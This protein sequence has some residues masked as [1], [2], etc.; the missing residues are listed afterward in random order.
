M[1]ESSKKKTPKKKQS[2]S[3]TSSDSLST[4][5]DQSSVKQSPKPTALTGSARKIKDHCA[6]WHNYIHKWETLNDQGFQVASQIVNCKLQAQSD[7]T[8]V[9]VHIIDTD[10]N[11]DSDDQGNT[12]PV[13]LGE[14]CE[15]L[16]TVFNSL[17]KLLKKM[18]TIC[19]DFKG[20]CDLEWHQ[21]DEAWSEEPIFQTWP[22]KQFHDS[23]C[24]IF[25]MY[26]TELDVK[27]TIL[28]EIAH[29]ND[30]DLMMFYVSTLL[31]QPYIEDKCK[32]LLES[33]LLETGHR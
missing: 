8:K 15:Q 33:M 23:S 5:G 25:T 26:K 12:M 22:T 7:K 2:S 13:E 14:Y 4:T 31:H 6:D 28:Q 18:E 30:R 10:G 17:A 11:N 32:T 3:S 16:E 20:V 29:T 24:E 19:K 27:K 1:A 21:N 9:G